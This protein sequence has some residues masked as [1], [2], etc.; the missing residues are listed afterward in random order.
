MENLEKKEEKKPPHKKWVVVGIKHGTV[1]TVVFADDFD[2][3]PPAVDKMI[4]LETEMS[5]N[6]KTDW[7]SRFGLV[8]QI[9]GQTYSFCSYPVGFASPMSSVYRTDW[10]SPVKV[11]IE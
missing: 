9:E 8:A 4:E 11:I 3:M 7:D 6:G 10:N 2:S 5:L 1:P